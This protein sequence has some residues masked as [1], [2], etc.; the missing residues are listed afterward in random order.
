MFQEDLI[1]IQYHSLL[2]HL[3]YRCYFDQLIPDGVMGMPVM[4]EAMDLVQHA[5]DYWVVVHCVVVDVEMLE[6][7]DGH[8]VRD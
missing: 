5:Q 2:P 3:N 6:D 8:R 1:L 4:V 7:A